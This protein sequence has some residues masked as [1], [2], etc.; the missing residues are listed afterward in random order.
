[1]GKIGI[2]GEMSESFLPG[3]LPKDRDERRKPWA[4]WRYCRDAQ[5][6]CPMYL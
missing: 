1:M 5:K 4:Q 6:S 3:A 2:P